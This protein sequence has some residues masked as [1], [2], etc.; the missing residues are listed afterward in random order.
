MSSMVDAP[1][2]AAHVSPV[3]HPAPPNR[4][5]AGKSPSVGTTYE[6]CLALEHDE[7]RLAR[8]FH[9]LVETIVSQF[10]P[11]RG[12][13]ILFAGA[14]SSSH[15]A[16]VAGY[17]ARQLTQRCSSGVI[18]VDADETDRVLSQRFAAVTEKG[19]VET[20]QDD[21]PA[22]KF[23][24][25]TTIMRLAFLA[26]GEHLTARRTI[27]PVAVRDVV[28]EWRANYRYTV[29][30]AGATLCPLAGLLA[31]QCDATYLVVQLGAADRQQTVITAQKL[32]AA[33]AR[34]LGSIATGVRP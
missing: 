17:V 8:Q 18:L 34:L 24:V 22:T 5:I 26:F 6:M 1:T 28:T 16:D 23:V 4:F 27:A 20:L 14:G 13:T 9:R 33:G 11:E 25:A 19:L 29:V 15:V 2:M 12:G 21:I 32:T 10:P 7:P 31:R 30:A 3:P